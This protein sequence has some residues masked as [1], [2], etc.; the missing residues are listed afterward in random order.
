[1]LKYLS[2]NNF[3]LIESLELTF[4]AGLNIITGETGAGKSIIVDALMMVLGE[5]ASME[6]I[7]H[8]TNK[9][10]I[11]GIFGTE[12]N[13]GIDLWLLK[14]GYESFGKE[15]IIRRELTQKGASRCFVNDSPASVGIVKEL[16]DLLVDF[17]GQHDH[18]SL[19]RVETHIQLLDNAGG[20]GEIKR[21]YEQ[22]YKQLSELVFTLYDLKQRE[23]SMKQKYEFQKFQLDEIEQ[24]IPIENEEELLNAELSLIENAEYL[25]S[26]TME[27]YSTLYEEEN[28]LR[29]KLLKIKSLLDELQ[30]IDKSFAEYY[31]ECQSS[32]VVLQEI[33][34]F[35]QNY[36]SKIEIQPERLEFIRVRIGKLQRLRKKYGSY[37]EVFSQWNILKDELSL[38]ENFDKEIERLNSE[39]LAMQNT[40]GIHAQRLSTKRTE[41]ASS[42]EYSIA[43]TLKHLGIPNANFKVVINQ[44][45]C[46]SEKISVNIGKQQF[47]AFPDGIDNVEFY[48]ST[49]SGEAPRPLS[50]VASGGEISRVMLALKSILAQ[51]DR[52]PLLVFDE[53]DTGISGRI[54]QKVGIAM[55]KLASFH[56]IIAITHLPQIAALADAHLAVEKTESNGRA[57]VKAVFL[58]LE[59]RIKEI[60]K[61][62]SGEKIT[63]ASIESAREL[64]E[65]RD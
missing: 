23:N 4:S 55:K 6:M 26:A 59:M 28:S 24:V 5:R 53:I 15:I 61:L 51:Q 16:G 56:Q 10:M 42:I 64:M 18:Q 31:S 30:Q 14:N 22:S 60:A 2:I 62:L 58:P 40:L 33:A 12:G 34:M 17:H 3:A 36:N 21:E 45:E 39:I 46:S 49:N 13:D 44:K 38:A 11:E 29:D 52:L 41:I 19:L 43:S 8:D 47:Q 54:S 65:I 50:K 7:R 37:E 57:V 32:I 35:A 48:I 9:A 63:Q 1:M 25:H 27:I 20:I